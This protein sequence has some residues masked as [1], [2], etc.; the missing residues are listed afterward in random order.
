[1]IF[2]AI[3]PTSALNSFLEYKIT[4]VLHKLMNL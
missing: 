4:K 3:K 1:M 2:I